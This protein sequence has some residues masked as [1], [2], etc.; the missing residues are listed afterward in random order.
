MFVRVQGFAVLG[1]DAVPVQVEVDVGNGLPAFEV[2]GLPDSCVREARE[3]VR[4]AIRNAGAD[5]PARR[6]TVNLAPASLRKVGGGFDLSMAL[7]ILAATGQA[8]AAPLAGLG[9]AGE[10]AL[11]GEVRRVPGLLA[12]GMA[13]AAA[14]CRALLAPACGAPEGALAG[15][16]VLPAADLAQVLAWLRG[17]QDLAPVAP[18]SPAAPAEPPADLAEVCGQAVARRALEVAAAGGHN[19]LLYGPPGVGK[20]LLARTLPGVLPPLTYREA[21]EVT[22]IYSAAGQ[23]PG[24]LMVQRPFRAPHHSASRSALLGGGTPPRP[25]ELSLAHCGVLFLDELPEFGRDSLEALRQPLEEGAVR[26]A[27]AAWRLTFPAR[28]MVVAAAN[29]CPCGYNGDG[30]RT[31]TCPPGVAERYRDRLSGPLIDRFDLQVRLGS[32]GPA[33][34]GAAPA[35]DSAAVARRVAAAHARQHQRQAAA[36]ADLRP[37]DL[38]RWVPLAPAA[39]SLL[40]DALQRLHLSLRGRDRVLKVAR[41]VA[42]LAGSAAVRAEHL[43]EAL[44][45]R[46]T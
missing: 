28:C 38:P 21:L 24:G 15:L 44:Q 34:W 42:D 12:I 14:G 1:V 22:R 7:G 29:P 20:S 2:V 9:V 30:R 25:G 3:R 23:D 8:P 18:A 33:E 39:A 5:F 36:N 19:L 45:Y 37:R 11:D 27:R 17:E 32:P 41:T 13:A 40:A 31:C 35:E 46:L 10:L 16:P 6:I 43:A 4:A 26:L